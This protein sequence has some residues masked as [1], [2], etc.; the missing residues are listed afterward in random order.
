MSKHDSFRDGQPANRPECDHEFGD[1]FIYC[2]VDGVVE[3]K[4]CKKCGL[5]SLENITQ[6]VSE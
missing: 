2:S 6:K 1:R 4:T 3:G 5:V